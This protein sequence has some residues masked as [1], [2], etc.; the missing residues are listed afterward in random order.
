MNAQENTQLANMSFDEFLD[1]KTEV[2]VCL[3]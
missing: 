2:F 3:M 1:F